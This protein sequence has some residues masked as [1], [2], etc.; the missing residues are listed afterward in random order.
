V[1][2]GPLRH[3]PDAPTFLR[4][5]GG[6]IEQI[7]EGLREAREIAF[8]AY[9]LRGQVHGQVMPAGLD[10]GRL[11]SMARSTI[12]RELEGCLLQRDLATGD[13]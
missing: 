6:I 4:V 8:E 13:A 11:V 9:G 10:H 1:T 7:A 5:L 3:E 2:L 12:N